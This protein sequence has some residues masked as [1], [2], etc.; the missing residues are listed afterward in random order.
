MP[1]CTLGCNQVA[2][3]AYSD[4]AL[5]VPKLVAEVNSSLQ[6]YRSE[7]SYLALVHLLV[8]TATPAAAGARV[9]SR[10]QADAHSDHAP[11]LAQAPLALR[12]AKVTPVPPVRST[13]SPP[14]Q[15]CNEK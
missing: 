10:R 15:Y 2:R 12:P 13:H 4:Q 9:S 5:L 14:R 11:H 8:A 3:V 7:L 1:D 6:Q